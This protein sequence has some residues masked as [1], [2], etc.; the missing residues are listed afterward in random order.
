VIATNDNW[1]DNSNSAD[2][3]TTAAQLGAAALSTGDTKSSALILTLQPGVYSFVASGKGATSGIVLLEVYDADAPTTSSMFVN[4]AARAYATTGNGVTIGGFVVS[5]SSP[6]KVLLRGVGATL[7]KQGIS[8]TDVLADPTIELHDAS[9]GNTTIAT[10][11]NWGDNT[12]APAIS[13]TAARIG[14]MPFDAGD[15]K[16]SALLVTLPSGVY[17]FVASG[18]SASSGVILVE[19]YDAD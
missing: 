18:K 14:A 15:A 17:S 2:I 4:I 8:Q 3:T 19:V 7:T 12:N 9:H 10:N 6:K 1:S 16:S 5:G 13:A 11:D